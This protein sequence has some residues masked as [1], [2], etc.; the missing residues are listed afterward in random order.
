MSGL[1]AGSR[2]LKSRASASS[3][4]P[5]LRQYRTRV[6]PIRGNAFH[7]WEPTESVRTRRVR[8]VCSAPLRFSDR[9]AR[10]STVFNSVTKRHVTCCTDVGSPR[11]R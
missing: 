1:T 10:S 5:A 3:A 7:I 9:N 8:S 4:T 11:N 6:D 2:V